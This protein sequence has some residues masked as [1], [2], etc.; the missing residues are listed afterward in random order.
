[1]GYGNPQKEWWAQPLN[2]ADSSAEAIILLDYAKCTPGLSVTKIFVHRRIKILTSSAFE[3]WGNLSFVIADQRI[4]DFECIV[5]NLENGVIVKMVVDKKS[6]LKEKVVKGIKRLTIALPGIKQGSVIEYQYTAIAVDFQIPDWTAQ[7]SVPVQW[8]EYD[9]YFG[10][11]FMGVTATVNGQYK[12][13]D[14]DKSERDW[15]KY[16]FTDLPAFTPEPDMPVEKYYKSSIN[17]RPAFKKGVHRLIYRLEMLSEFGLTRDSLKMDSKIS[18]R[19]DLKLAEADELQGS[20]SIRMSG[21]EAA[22]VRKLIRKMGKE[23]Y[24]KKELE[25]RNWLIK[26]KEL[27]NEQDST[28]DIQMDVDLNILDQI[29]KT[30]SLIYINPFVIFKEESNPFRLET[31]RYPLDLG[32]RLV[33]TTT[34]VI[35]IPEGYVVDELPKNISLELPERTMIFS[36]N[37]SVIGNSVYITDLFRTT[38][39]IFNND[40]Y[41]LLREFYGRMIAKKAEAVVFRKKRV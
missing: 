6:L 37:S 24:L 26:G 10:R 23:D 30:D 9:V 34:T 14:L 28:R 27:K 25:V 3:E 15:I 39:I 36:M 31:R 7:S 13:T 22:K 21:Y 32:S 11:N 33:K 2:A 18:A 17:F 4:A 41:P 29:Q 8:S 5:Y 40:E 35:L 38:R 16:V 12:L 20:I 19:I 1:M